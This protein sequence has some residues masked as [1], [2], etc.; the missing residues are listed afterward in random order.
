ME[1]R[2]EENNIYMFFLSIIL[3]EIH[4]NIGMT[5]VLF[6]DKIQYVEIL[7]NMQRLPGTLRTLL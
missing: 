1:F 6:M 4:F 3:I 5:P 7:V 2:D